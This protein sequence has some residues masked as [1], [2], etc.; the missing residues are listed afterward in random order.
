MA[1]IKKLKV[2]SPL[3]KTART[4]AQR[5]FNKIGGSHLIGR[6][7][8]FIPLGGVGTGLRGAATLIQKQCRTRKKFN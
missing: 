4:I 5:N 7:T 2:R 3:F 8:A 6:T 1:L